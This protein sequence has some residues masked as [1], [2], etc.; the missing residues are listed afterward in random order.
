MSNTTAVVL[1]TRDL[2]IHDNPALHAAARHHDLVVPLFVLDDGILQGSYNRPNRARFLAQSLADLD[3]ALA[4]LGA[5][6]VI[7]RG[8][9]ERELLDVVAQVGAEAV[10]L[11][12]DIS[13]YARRR[14]D[15]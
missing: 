1:F 12:G 15:R 7:R 11:A 4:G 14:E 13:T 10:H 8:D 2:R 6:L 9:V 3:Q 5:H